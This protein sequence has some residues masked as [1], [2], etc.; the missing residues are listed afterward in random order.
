MNQDS[1]YYQ[2][3]IRRLEV[4]N[5]K[6]YL[7]I[8]LQGLI[9]TGLIGLSVF[10]LLSFAELLGNFSSLVRTILLFVFILSILAYINFR[11]VFPLFNYFKLFVKRNY[12]ETAGKVGYHFPEIKDDLKNAMQLISVN[13]SRFYSSILTDA[14]FKSI[15]EKTRLIKFDSIIRFDSLKKP[16]LRLLSLLFL[17]LLFIFLI[18]GLSG[19]SVRLIKFDREFIPPVRFQIVVTPGNGEVTRGADFNIIIKIRGD[20]P[21]NVNLFSRN[22]E[23]TDYS[24]IKLTADS[25]DQYVYEI[26]SVRTSFNYFVQADEI[27]SEIFRID[28]IDRPIIKTITFRITPPAYSRIPS[29]EQ[30]DNGNVVSLIGSR[31]DISLTSTKNLNSATIVFDDTTQT[32]LKVEEN[33]AEGNFR[34]KKETSYKV[35]IKDENGNANQ[36]PINYFIKPINDELPTIEL[37]EPGKDIPLSNDNRVP[38]FVKI[39]DD[40]GFTKLLLHFRLT[41]SK[42]EIIPE[43]FTSIEIPVSSTQKE[44]DIFYV[45][46]LTKLSPAVDDIYSYYLEIFDNDNVNGPKSAKT[47]VYNVRVP[48]LDEILASVDQL[49]NEA[50]D[51]LTKTLQEAE[52]LKKDLEKIDQEL[53][54]DKRD[55]TWEEKDKIEKAL[56]NFEQL[57]EKMSDVNENLKKMQQDLQ[58]NDLLSQ[59]TLEKYMELQDL[60]SELTSDEM[61]KAMEKLRDILEQMNRNMTQNEMQNFKLD[62]ERFRKSIERTLNLL[63]RLQIEQKFDEMMK[64]TE[65]IAEEQDELNAQTKQSEKNNNINSEQLSKKQDEITDQL[66]KLSENMEELNDKMQTLEDM[67]NEEMEKILEELNKQMNEKLSQQASEKMKQNQMQKARQNQQQVS[68]NMQQLM[69]IL[70]QMKDQMMQQNQMQVFLD[71]MRILDN[72][73]KLSQQQEELKKES[74]RLDPNSSQFTENAQNQNNLKQSLNRLLEQL[75]DLSQK[76]FAISPEMGKALGSANQQMSASIQA[77]QNRNGSFAAV[78]Q[79]EA[80]KNLNEAA[81][82]MKNSMESMMQSGGSGGGMMSL[83]Q[84]LQQ[85]S[86]QQMDL[87]NMTQML[88]QMMQGNLSPGQQAELQRLG[89]QQDLIRKSLEQLNEE[90]KMSGESKKI[91]ADLEEIVRRMQEVVSD[92]NTQRL[93]DELIQKQERILSKLLDAQRSI[94]ERDFEKERRSETGKQFVRQSPSELNLSSDQVKNKIR[95][96]LNRAVREGFNRDFEDLIKRYFEALQ[97]EEINN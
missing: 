63:K 92:M 23:Q 35:L 34:I 74:E 95:D 28:V 16:A 38:L 26:K 72:L 52:Q 56:D 5:R 6:E 29:Y 48:S 46:N 93:D 25:L 19:A 40:F 77:M 1:T 27:K 58:K 44:S 55:L 96:E 14:A 82:M 9:K 89:Q 21:V 53:K 20:S 91:P 60:M 18:P 65:R 68:Q 37:L 17:T 39:Y 36:N 62:E 94:N 2:E 12:L 41:K 33:S 32:E 87:N 86:G 59:E 3:I 51:E 22:D 30:K 79:S 31:I 67:P 10:V 15:Y 85:M 71:M 43:K 97:K 7:L 4:T 13:D 78:T 54:N 42:Y 84:Q 81:S 24:V 83:M 49:Q 45:W 47:P 64:R 57:Q 69:D 88:Q 11:V 80:M 76:T 50:V 8:I 73:L 75:S 70:Q 90:A 61:K 66:H